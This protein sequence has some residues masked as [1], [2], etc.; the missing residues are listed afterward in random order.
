[1][2]QVQIMVLHDR[3]ALVQAAAERFV[4][5]SIEAIRAR[6]QF[7]V[8]LSGGST[9]KSLYGLLA[10]KG[11]AARIDWSRVHLFWGDE[12]CVPPTDPLSNYRMAR[13]TLIDYVP[14]PAGNVHRI[15]GEDEPAAA[16][17]AYEIELRQVLGT[18]AGFDLVLLGMGED[19]HTASLFPQLTAVRERERWSMAEYVAAVSAWRITCTPVLLNASAA[20]LFL[21]S[22]G[23]KAAPL[24][25]VLEGPYPPDALPA[26]VVAPHDGSVCW[27]LDADA[28]AD[29]TEAAVGP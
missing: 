7:H 23:K 14:L 27:L 16:A 17:A 21:V 22:G 5:A 18:G 29:L 20:V 10:T 8:A 6:G 25:Q 26:R 11:Y 19:G 12:R 28:A 9:P 13:E 4:A 24:R 2:T 1:M 15:R 3:S